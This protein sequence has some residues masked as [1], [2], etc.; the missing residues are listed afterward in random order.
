MLIYNIITKIKQNDTSNTVI[1]VVSGLARQNKTAIGIRRYH[2]NKAIIVET[3]L[4]IDVY[5]NY[6]ST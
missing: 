4:S 3:T 5:L 1:A 6:L 2:C